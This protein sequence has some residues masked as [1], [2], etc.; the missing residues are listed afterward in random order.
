MKKSII[1]LALII[2]SLT[3]NA[4]VI[5]FPYQYTVFCYS[6]EIIYSYEKAKK[7][8][9]TT[10]Y[11]A[12]AGIV[13]SFL[14]LDTPVAGLEIAIE[15][16]HYFK[17]DIFNGFFISGYIGTAYMTNFNDIS[18]IGLVP[19]FKLNYKKNLS[20]KLILEPYVSLSLPIT[21]DVKDTFFYFPSPALTIGA[22][23]GISK[24]RTE[25]KK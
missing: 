8:R 2:K 13:G 7:L 16:R 9:N 22:R 14:H 25:Y 1:I 10:N 3:A 23:I 5:F 18:H 20:K 21:Y 19:G 17:P 12:G 11:W 6:A 24:L 4:D 15:K